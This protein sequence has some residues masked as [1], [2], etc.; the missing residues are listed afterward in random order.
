LITVIA[1][2]WPTLT[3]VEQQLDLTERT[4]SLRQRQLW[5]QSRVTLALPICQS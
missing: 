5:V 2:S 4:L 1:W 3:P